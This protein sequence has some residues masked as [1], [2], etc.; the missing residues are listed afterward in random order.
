MRPVVLLL[1]L[2]L[3]VPLA[4]AAAHRSPHGGEQYRVHPHQRPGRHGAPGR[5]GSRQPGGGG[6][7]AGARRPA[8]LRRFTRCREARPRGHRY[9]QRREQRD[10]RG[11]RAEACPRQRARGHGEPGCRRPRGRPRFHHHRRPA[12]P[13]GRP[14]HRH[15][16]N[17]RRQC[18]GGGAGGVAARADGGRHGRASRRAGRPHGD[19]G[20][21]CHPHRRRARL[22]APGWRRCPARSPG[23]APS[24]AAARSTPR[25]T[26]ATSS[27]D[28]HPPWA[29]TSSSSA[30]AGGITS[31]FT[32]RGK[33]GPSGTLRTSIG[34]GGAAIT[35]RTF[36]GQISLVKQPEVDVN[37]AAPGGISGTSR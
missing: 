37:P 35:A 16:G 30:P 17:A 14:A 3:P 2:L 33:P 5:M 10:A 4:R 20:E 22:R 7:T 23:R 18:R 32:L 27:C 8:L 11:A 24:S 36:R 1:T 6:R 28:C 26:A 9:R 12:A 15:G 13:R 25:R 21:R 34:D 19:H 31:E 29:P